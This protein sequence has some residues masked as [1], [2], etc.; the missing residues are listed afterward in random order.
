M[1]LKL[2]LVKTIYMNLL[3]LK[4]SDQLAY[5]VKHV[6]ETAHTRK[7]K[8]GGIG[9]S[10]AHGQ[11]TKRTYELSRQYKVVKR[12]SE[13]DDQYL[14]GFV[15]YM[16]DQGY[17]L[18]YVINVVSNFKSLVQRGAEIGFKRNPRIDLYKFPTNPSRIIH[19]LS[20]DEIETIKKLDISPRRYGL[21]NTQKWLI[22]GCSIGQRGGD[23]LNITKENIKVIDGIRVIELTQQKTGKKVTI[24]VLPDVAE[25]IDYAWPYKT[26]KNSFN[27]NVKI[28]CKLAGMTEE[29]M[30]RRFNMKTSRAVER[31]YPKYELIST[32]VCRRSFATNYYGILPTPLIKQI[33]GHSSEEMLLKYIGKSD[34]DFAKQTI[35]ILDEKRPVKEKAPSQDATMDQLWAQSTT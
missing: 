4:V 26:N 1:Y 9:L 31:L 33:T 16:Q 13:V 5:T 32:H 14:A 24:P 29:V 34:I 15:E 18:T 3:N 12:L 17:L 28:L 7:N 25:I 8:K 21:L 11:K 10:A 27:Q 19:T 35:A 2:A 22:M 30:G 23:L 20:F 6:L